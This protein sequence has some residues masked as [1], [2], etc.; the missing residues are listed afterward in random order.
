MTKRP[1]KKL[2]GVSATNDAYAVEHNRRPFLFAMT[3]ADGSIVESEGNVRPE[4]CKRLSE[5]FQ[6]LMKLAQMAEMTD[7]V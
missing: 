7:G 5:I 6:E 2:K 3:F 1:F 4:D